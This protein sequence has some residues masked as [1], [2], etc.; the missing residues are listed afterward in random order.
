M[1]RVSFI[2]NDWVK[3]KPGELD[4]QPEDIEAGHP[5]YKMEGRR[6]FPLPDNDILAWAHDF[7]KKNRV[8]A[9]TRI[10]DALVSTVFLGHNY[11]FGSGPPLVFETMIFR[12]GQGDEQWRCTTYRQAEEQHAK[13][14]ETLK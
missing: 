8:V 11:R 2:I 13:A 12:D 10:G 7:D 6:I 5:F 1:R 4:Q 9:K 14:V 3:P